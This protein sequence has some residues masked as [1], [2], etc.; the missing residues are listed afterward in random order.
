MNVRAKSLRTP[1]PH[2]ARV[3]TF[4]WSLADVVRPM[5]LAHCCGEGYSVIKD[6]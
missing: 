1:H 6:A 4:K 5:V 3:L 2:T